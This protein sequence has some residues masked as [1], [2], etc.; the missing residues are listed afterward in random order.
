VDNGYG[1]TTENRGILISINAF[2]T[3]NFTCN[4]HINSGNENPHCLLQIGENLRSLKTPHIGKKVS[5]DN[6]HFLLEG[7]Q[8]A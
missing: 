7:M 5:N 6:I 3:L 2:K 1:H 8:I 4:D